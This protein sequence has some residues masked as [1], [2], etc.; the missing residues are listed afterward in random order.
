MH[1]SVDVSAICVNIA[2]FLSLQKFYLKYNINHTLIPSM[3]LRDRQTDRPT[4]TYFPFH[5]HT[6]S[7]L[8]TRI[9]TYTYTYYIRWP[10]F[11]L[12]PSRRSLDAFNYYIFPYIRV[13][14]F[15]INVGVFVYTHSCTY[16]LWIH[17]T[18][19]FQRK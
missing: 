1:L 16:I 8:Y 12:I 14:K 18:N 7:F 4:D 15:N 11:T 3:E 6:L 10:L 13:Q 19:C 9:I 5:Q 17:T 2:V